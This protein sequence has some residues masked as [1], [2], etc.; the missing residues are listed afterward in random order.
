MILKDFL[1]LI[2]DEEARIELE[3]DSK[4]AEEYSY[5]S[6]WLSDYRSDLDTAKYYNDYNDYKVTGFKF[7][8]EFGESDV[9]IDIIKQ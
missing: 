3:I 9:T 7:N 6:F 8:T 4:D 1:K 2:T 5:E